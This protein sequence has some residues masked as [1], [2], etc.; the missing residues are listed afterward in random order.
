MTNSVA[1]ILLSLV[2]VLT[3]GI[4]VMA[5]IRER[6][7]R[8]FKKF[9]LLTCC[10]LCWQM[11]NIVFF[12]AKSDFAARYL[13]DL[14]IPF[15][16]FSVI[17]LFAFTLDF[18]RV[19]TN[20]KKSNLMWA[21]FS[22]IPAVTAVIALTSP[23][24]TLLRE[25]L[26]VHID[27]VLTTTENN[28]GPWF[29][30]H[31]IYSYLV[32][33]VTIM[34]GMYQHSRLP[35]GHRTASNSLIL[36]ISI[37]M[38]SNIMVLTDVV[39][40]PLDITLLGLSFS[41]VFV[42]FAMSQHQKVD[43]VL[44]AHNEVFNCMKEAVFIVDV[45]Q[46]V[47]NMNN[48]AGRWLNDI[49]FPVADRKPLLTSAIEE[50]LAAMRAELKIVEDVDEG[51]DIYFPSTQSQFK[52]Y[53]KQEY[54][55]LNENNVHAGTFV[56][57]LDVTRNRMLINRLEQTSGIDFLTGLG[58]R[59]GLNSGKARIDK[60]DCL[61][62][63]VILGDLNGLKEI[64]DKYGHS[65]GDETI[66]MAADILVEAAA[67]N[68]LVYRYGGDE[69]VVLLPNCDRESAERVMKNIRDKFAGFEGENMQ[70]ASMALGLAIK[71]H[72]SQ[73][74]DKLIAEADAAMYQDKRNNRRR[75]EQDCRASVGHGKR[76]RGM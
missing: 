44:L 74:L 14:K 24:H 45:K 52:I 43:F 76:V 27:A 22:I 39:T 5:I 9:V 69:Y 31:T 68:G 4:T 25:S 18:Y 23:W 17:A 10:L 37:V 2:F 48:S 7:Y 58:N 20:G 75:G 16:A 40:S 49:G 8:I 66:I 57:I 6:E 54:P 65:V 29:W 62:I 41:I 73:E 38:I 3:L 56:T 50:H 34:I 55:V 59:T 64:N 15:V 35:K 61:P 46:E 67:P 32:M 12:L 63:S 70:K 13:F 60:S 53:N 1:I 26:V 42:Y 19:G 11:S 21:L 71:D 51:V 28:R 30:V 36:G 33:M 72:E 47:V